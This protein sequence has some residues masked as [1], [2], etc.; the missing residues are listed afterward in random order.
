MTSGGHSHNNLAD[1]MRTRQVEKRKRSRPENGAAAPKYEKTLHAQFFDQYEG[2]LPE[3]VDETHLDTLNSALTFV[4]ALLREAKRQFHEEGDAGRLAAFTAVGALSQFAALFEKPHLETFDAPITTLMTALAALDCNSVLP[5][6][7]PTPRSGRAPS[8]HAHLALKGH[9]AA[10]VR[11]LVNSGL[12]RQQAHKSVARELQRLK[13][14]AE[15]GSGDLTP[16]TVRNWCNEVSSD[17]GRQGTAA[18]IH[19]TTLTDA[20]ERQLAELL[21]N[22]DRSQARQFA[23]EALCRWVQRHSAAQKVS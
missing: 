8:S 20:S 12:N 1:P 2:T 9:S 17:V 5:I 15:R 7:R 19:D 13:V 22:G 10:A 11:R 21:R 4:F 6:V 18:I 3:T 16:T 14:R 23:L